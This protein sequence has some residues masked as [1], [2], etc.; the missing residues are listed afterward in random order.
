MTTTD[1]RT[2]DLDVPALLAQMTLQEKA[3][4]CSGSDFWHTRAVERLGVP[5]VM[6]TDGP[7]GLRKQ[8]GAADHLGL[9]DSVPAT[10][11]PPAVALGSS[12]DVELVER[13]GQALGA[14]AR[15]EGVAVLL[16]PGINIKRSPLCGRNFE[17]LSEDPLVSGVL[18]AALVRGI[19]SAGIGACVKH[20]AVNNQET[21]R[22]RVSAEVDERTLREIY[23]AGF[24]RVVTEARPWTVMCSYNKINGTYASQHPWLLTDVLRGEWG[25]DGMVM[26]DWGAV[27]DRVAGL[28]AGLDLEMPASGG[29]GEAAIVAAVQS[30]ALDESVVDR[31]AERVLTLLAR[32]LP[33]L[34]AGGEVDHAAHHELAREAAAASAVLLKNDPVDGSPLLPVDPEGSGTVAV[35]GEFARTPR[36]QGAGS[37]QVTPTRLDDAWTTL[38]DGLG[39]RA[40]FAP[41]VRIDDG[42]TAALQAEA[43]EVARTADVVLLFLGLPA[44]AES[45]GYDREHIHLPAAQTELLAAVAEVNP[46]VVVVLS[47]GSTVQ[48]SDWDHHAPAILEGWLL[49]QAGGAALADLLLGRV[50]PSGRLAET[51][52]LRLEDTPAHLNFP[53]EGGK[54]RYGEGVFVGYRGYDARRQEVSYPFGHGLSYTTFA[55]SDLDVHVHDAEVA[56]AV[57]VTNTGTRAGAEVVQVY[58]GDPEARVARPE[59]ELKAFRKVVL[60]PGAAVRVEFTLGA[61][62][63]SYVDP[64]SGE[65]VLEGGRFTVAAGSSSRD[66]PVTAEFVV[67][68]PAVATPLR[69]DATLDEVLAHPVS[70]PAL[71]ALIDARAPNKLTDPAMRRMLGNFPL[72]RMTSF[73]NSPISREEAT[74]LLGYRP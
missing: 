18:G 53:G 64:V 2:T 43:V 36:Y 4:L 21:E 54:V 22:L 66:L 73:P 26:S 69:A 11:F 19:Q 8:A 35:I 47:N 24:E 37:S 27:D 61:R 55:Y 45:E 9:N 67:D 7:H 23:L 6:L 33:A 58:V 71:D 14:E 16:G 74:E 70:G 41:G 28:A 59:R 51:I 40:V 17:Y 38:R 62:D 32:A 31:A 3:S 25:F 15:A 68:A 48:V 56:V 60:E 39:D 1:R 5:A 34:E 44:A 10:C 42:E 13:V 12:F 72:M 30:G 49:G 29:V 20:F 65:W 52:P 50:N 46:R 63:L 57:T